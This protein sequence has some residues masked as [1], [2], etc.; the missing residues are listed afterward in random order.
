MTL[1]E[2]HYVVHSSRRPAF[3]FLTYVGP[4]GKSLQ[5]K[6]SYPRLCAEW[7]FCSGTGT[8]EHCARLRAVQSKSSV[9]LSGGVSCTEHYSAAPQR[10]AKQTDSLRGNRVEN[11]KPNE[12]NDKTRTDLSDRAARR[13]AFAISRTWPSQ[14]KQKPTLHSRPGTTRAHAGAG[15]PTTQSRQRKLSALCLQ[16]L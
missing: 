8:I 11:L 7:V 3:G 12:F 1:L 13:S 9:L 10:H 5:L 6:S 15:L 14:T 16:R 4:A 2:A